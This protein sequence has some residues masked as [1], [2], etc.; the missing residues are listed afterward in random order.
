MKNE[1]LSKDEMEC[2]RCDGTGKIK[3]V[4]YGHCDVCGA[5]VYSEDPGVIKE[6]CDCD[7]GTF[8]VSSECWSFMPKVTRVPRKQ[9]NSQLTSSTI[10]T[11]YN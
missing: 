6:T 3:L 11:L 7:K 5:P 9:S 4:L 2:S 1:E 10:S 8:V